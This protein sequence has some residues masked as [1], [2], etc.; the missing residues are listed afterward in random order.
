MDPTQA[1]E[2]QDALTGDT[3]LTGSP[4]IDSYPIDQA[5]YC[6]NCGYD[7]RGTRVDG[8]CPECGLLPN[9]LAVMAELRRWCADK[10]KAFR[11]TAR[12][13]VGAGAFF[14]LG[15]GAIWSFE[16]QR[17]LSALVGMLVLSVAAMGVPLLIFSYAVLT[18]DVLAHRRSFAYRNLAQTHKSRV[19][20]A[21]LLCGSAFI[22]IGL[23]LA[24]LFV[25]LL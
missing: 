9:L 16:N 11:S 1:E 5:V 10:K 4:S 15:T 22:P 14:L 6:P 21:C 18:I 17:L 3:I 2:P 8:L 13:A 25:V 24:G 23:G 19:Y 12:M 20:W 7:L